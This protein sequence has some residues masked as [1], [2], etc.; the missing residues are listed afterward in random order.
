[1]TDL[2]G[3]LES[4]SEDAM[5]VRDDNGALTTIPLADVV[6]GKPVPPRP[7]VR[8][9]VSAEDAERRAVA[10]W[11]PLDREPLGEWLLRAAGGFSSRA[12]SVLA[13][14]DPGVPF[15]EA[16][17]VVRGYY[18][19]RSLPAW[20]QVVTMSTAHEAFT[21]AGWVPARPG[22]ADTVFSLGSVAAALRRTRRAA[23]SDVPDVDMTAT[24]GADWLA[25][26]GRA[27]SHPEEATGVLQGPEQVGFAAVHDGPRVVAKGR[28]A[29][30]RDDD[31]AG[32]TDVWVAPEHRRRG[33]AVLVLAR[34][35][36]WAAERGVTTAYLQVRGDNEPALALYDRLGF[37]AHHAYRYLA[38]RR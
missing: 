10:S 24:A 14:G 35:L 4:W 26:D 33:L 8:L 21:A 32:I 36:E 29:R 13:V 38:P 5:S 28:I 9:R 27:G 3:V 17:A 25:D 23:P 6:T 37:T 15:A 22:E 7:S 19:D 30:G 12:N 20:A 11:P 18:S 34:L 2:L 1:M 16:L 31:W